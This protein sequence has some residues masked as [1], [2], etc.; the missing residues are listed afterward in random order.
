MTVEVAPSWRA[1]S[2]TGYREPSPTGSAL[3][4]SIPHSFGRAGL[5]APLA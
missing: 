3:R 4:A 5:R 2:R 1:A